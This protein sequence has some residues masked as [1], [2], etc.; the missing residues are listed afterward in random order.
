VARF[1]GKD[2]GAPSGGHWG[3]YLGPGNAITQRFGRHREE[4]AAGRGVGSPGYPGR[5]CHALGDKGLRPP[6][7][8]PPAEAERGGLKVGPPHATKCR[9]S[10]PV[11]EVEL[12]LL[13]KFSAGPGGSGVW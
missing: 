9:T 6:V 7:I 12:A 4:T 3:G 5:W 2:R 8:T 1:G 13:H 10:G 11:K